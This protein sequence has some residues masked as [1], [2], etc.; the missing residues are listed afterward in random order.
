M[1]NS[2]GMAIHLNYTKL[3]QYDRPFKL[4]FKGTKNESC[5]VSHDTTT[6]NINNETIFLQANFEE[7]CIGVFERDGNIIYNHTILVTF[8]ANPTSELVFREEEIAFEVECTK[9]NNITVHLNSAYMN[10][11]NLVKQTFKKCEYTRFTLFY[12]K[13]VLKIVYDAFKIA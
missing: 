12:S 7:C 8:G 4:H 1:C 5:S 13:I 6:N 10:V 11:T 9:L 2:T 3:S